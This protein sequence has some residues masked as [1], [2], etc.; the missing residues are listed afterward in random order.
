[1]ITQVNENEVREAYDDVRA[2]SSET[3]WY[4]K[5]DNDLHVMQ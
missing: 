2:D 1:M 4:N 5:E 3:Q